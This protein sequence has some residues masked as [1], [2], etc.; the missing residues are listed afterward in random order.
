MLIAGRPIRDLPGA[1]S[2]AP[3][4]KRAACSREARVG[5][6]VIQASGAMSSPPLDCLRPF[7]GGGGLLAGRRGGLAI[8]IRLIIACTGRCLR[9]GGGGGGG[10]LTVVNEAPIDDVWRRVCVNLTADTER[11]SLHDGVLALAYA[12][13]GHVYGLFARKLAFV[14]DLKWRFEWRG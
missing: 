11:T 1:R 7:Q 6:F 5:A 9:L 14:L 3:H 2:L 13:G 8:C 10:G 4:T 12:H